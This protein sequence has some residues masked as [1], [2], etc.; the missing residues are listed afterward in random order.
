MTSAA[1]QSISAA[2][3]LSDSRDP[4]GGLRSGHP[5]GGAPGAVLVSLLVTKGEQQGVDAIIAGLRA[6]EPFRKLGLHSAPIVVVAAN[7]EERDRLLRHLAGPFDT[8]LLQDRQQQALSSIKEDNLEIDREGHRVTVG[9]QEVGLTKMEF[10][11]LVTLVDRKD[12]VLDR[13]TLLTDVWGISA[14]NKTRTVDTHIKRLRDKLRGAGDLVQSVRGVGYRFSER[15]ARSARRR[16]DV[17][18]GVHGSGAT[19]GAG[20]SRSR[21]DTP[22]TPA[23]RRT[24]D[25]LVLA[26]GCRAR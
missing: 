26:A 14:Q 23:E 25:T 22:A 7:V 17:P 8:V 24:V 10:K 1:R 19:T 2:A 12:R 5:A 9:G 18:S 21:S 4:E 20:G 11:L 16:V 6:E 3:Y 13:A 15:L